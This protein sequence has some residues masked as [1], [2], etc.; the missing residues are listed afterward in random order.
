ML[1]ISCAALLIAASIAS[2]AGQPAPVMVPLTEQER[3]VILGMCEDATWAAQRRFAGLCQFLRDKFD[4]AAK[5]AAA[6]A[7]EQPKKE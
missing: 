5:K 2:A 7:P 1:R 4:E 6:P 3:A